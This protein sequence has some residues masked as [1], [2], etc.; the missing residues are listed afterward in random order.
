MEGGLCQS[1][2]EKEVEVGLF[3]VV[4]ESHVLP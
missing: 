3:E 2:M 4:V 1:N